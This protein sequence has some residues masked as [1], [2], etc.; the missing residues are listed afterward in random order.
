[1]PRPGP[2]PYECVRR[3]WHSERH[4]PMR[5]SIIQQIFRVVHESHSSQTRKNREWQQK[6]PLVVL[7]AEEIMYSKANSEAE[8][9]NLDT[10][11]DRVN[12]AINTIIRRDESTETGELLPP[13]V[14]AALNL[15]CIPVRASRSQRHS[16]PR[17]YLNLRPQ[18]S[19]SMPPR[20]VDRAVD[21]QCPKL[22]ALHSGSSLNF[23]KSSTNLSSTYSVSQSNCHVIGND[24]LA[25]P[26]S[27]SSFTIPPG[28][29]RMMTEETN[30]PMKLGS[31]YPLYYGTHFGTED[32][33]L[34]SQVSENVKA[35]PIFVGKPVGMS[36]PEP[37]EMVVS[38]NLFSCP[39]SDITSKRITQQD[40]RET[41]KRPLATDCDLS[42]RLGL[43]AG[44]CMS[45]DR[46]SAHETEDAG[47]SSSQEEKFINHSSQGRKEFSFFPGKTADDP[48]ESCSTKWFPDGEFHNLEA[49]VRKSK[50][51]FHDNL[52]NVQFC[53]QPGLPSNQVTGRIRGP[54]L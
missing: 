18:E 3:A 10:L 41:H 45:M 15:G 35:T 17:T 25:A 8:Y 49:T 27:Y 20:L 26:H 31:V 54:G 40:F 21:E 4:Q 5:G 44:S 23:A 22:S 38:Q 2:R 30:N 39:G 19:P 28:H 1:M 16:N 12:D 36:I 33:R 48:F 13:C 46:S 6:L 34:G 11:W 51:P 14:E 50:A 7:K 43:V 24:N 32:P 37:S 53:L 42:L 29:N 52:D 9:T 47:S